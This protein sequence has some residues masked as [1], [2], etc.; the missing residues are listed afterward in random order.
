MKELIFLLLSASIPPSPEGLIDLIKEGLEYSYMEKYSEA[1]SLFN[2]VIEKYPDDPAGYFFKAA[3]LDLYMLDFSI[4]LREKEFFQLLKEAIE[5]AKK[6][7]RSSDSKKLAWAHFYK[8][9]SLSYMAM[10]QGRKRSFLK[11]LAN[12][13]SAV[14]ELKAAIKYDSTLYDA[15]L[16]LG[17]YDYIISELPKFLKWLPFFGDRKEE[18]L[19]KIRIASEKSIFARVAGKDA[20]AW[21]LAY[22]G[23]PKEAIKIARDLIKRYPKSRSF[24]W[25]LAYA[26]R[27][28]GRW[29]EARDIYLE[30]LS[31]VLKEQKEYPY[32][33]A[34]TSYWISKTLYYSREWEMALLYLDV[35]KLILKEDRSEKEYKSLMKDF[36]KL[37]TKILKRLHLVE[38]F[39]FPNRIRE[40]IR[41]GN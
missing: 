5:R 32:D 19:R 6:W 29:R 13:L 38:E 3:L 16:G 12:G 10:R 30:L 15:Y 24:R 31:L 28:A 25:T 40:V 33:I 34:V 1:E 20:L 35:G 4:D 7:E 9:A 37:E 23:K 22:D 14:N 17:T 8:G 27:R 41:E 39:E 26:L 2:L 18:A 11:A 21:T 36:E